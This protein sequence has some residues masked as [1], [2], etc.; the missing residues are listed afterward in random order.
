VRVGPSASTAFFTEGAAAPTVVG[1][2]S[3]PAPT[4][5]TNLLTA[6]R[7]T[8]ITSA[9]TANSVND[10]RLAATPV[11]RGE[12]FGPAAA[13]GFFY[14]TRWA[15]PSTTALQRAV[16][17][18]VGSTAALS[19]TQDP[20]ALTN[21]IAV[22]NAAADA[23]LQLLHNDGSGVATKIDLGASFPAIS[24][25]AMYELVLFC[26]PNGDEVTWRVTRLDTGDTVVGTITTDLPA[27]TTLLYPRAYNNNGGTAAAVILDLMRLYLETDY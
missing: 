14:T 2:A 26:K 11:Y 21:T 9:A 25:T 17:G 10:V 13:G 1:T 5:G 22:G 3:T 8:R 19:A 6:T 15:A 18:L 27:K 24:L 20:A 23:N 16:V 7:R 12:A 4:A